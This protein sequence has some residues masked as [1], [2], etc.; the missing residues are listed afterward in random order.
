MDCIIVED[1]ELTVLTLQK[2]IEREGGLTLKEVF[3]NGEDAFKYLNSHTCDLVFLDVE[4]GGM[5]GIDM[6]KQ[7]VNCPKVIVVSFNP[8]YAAEAFNIDVV[9][10]IVKPLTYDRFHKAVQKLGVTHG[11]P[12]AESKDYFYVKDRNKMVQ[13]FYKDITYIEALED[14]VK[15]HTKDKKYTKLSTMKAMEGQFPKNDFMRIHRSYIVRLDKIREIEENSVA[16]EG[17]LIPI[18]RAYMEEFMK[19]INQL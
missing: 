5:S 3:N 18:S 8:V 7:L 15:I 16:V 11:S 9:D 19:R 14:Y 13:V 1:N 10:Y 4:M 12:H 6:I 2:C 17:A